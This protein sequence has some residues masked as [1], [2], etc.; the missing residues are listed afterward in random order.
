MEKVHVWSKSLTVDSIDSIPSP[1]LCCFPQPG[2]LCSPFHLRSFKS[3]I[4]SENISWEIYAEGK[5][6]SPQR[7][8]SWT[9]APGSSMGPGFHFHQPRV[10]TCQGSHF[11]PSFPWEK[12][13]FIKIIILNILSKLSTLLSRGWSSRPSTVCPDLH[14]TRSLPAEK[15][16]HCWSVPIRDYIKFKI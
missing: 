2:D 15:R 4:G 6:C 8:C 12:L 7:L 13:N 3:K 5:T 14:W 1:V 9:P 11:L 10:K 16:R